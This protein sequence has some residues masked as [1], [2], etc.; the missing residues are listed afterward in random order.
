MIEYRFAELPLRVGSDGSGPAIALLSGVAT[1]YPVGGGYI[2]DEVCID[3]P[4]TDGMVRMDRKHRLFA[5]IS[6]SLVATCDD[7][8]NER[9]A[10]WHMAMVE[11]RA[12]VRRELARS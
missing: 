5:S 11:E 7:Q 3:D 1:I 8:I 6:M 2:V 4:V 9:L 10:D 12:I